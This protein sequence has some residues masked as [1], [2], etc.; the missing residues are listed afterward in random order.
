M[1]QNSVAQH[2]L[3]SFRPQNLFESILKF[4]GYLGSDLYSLKDALQKKEISVDGKHIKKIISMGS[5][6]HFIIFK[7]DD[8]VERGLF[9]KKLP[10]DF[11]PL[12]LRAKYP[13]LSFYKHLMKS[14][15]WF[16]APLAMLSVVV[17]F[18]FLILMMKG[19]SESILLSDLIHKSLICD[20]DC[21][22][23][24]VDFSYIQL[25]VHATNLVYILFP[26][27]FSVLAYFKLKNVYIRRA[28]IMQG[29]LM[30]GV[31]ISI[32]LKND[33]NFADAQEYQKWNELKIEIGLEDHEL[34]IAPFLS[35]NEKR[36]I[37]SEESH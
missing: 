18:T 7:K 24:V 11:N 13:L 27:L 10:L 23:K 8:Q 6:L 17:F 15:H 2:N 32:G 25:L 19:N 28:V 35:K 5:D 16:M 4:Y 9:V 37:A 21:V 36:E 20:Q 31:G 29:I 3:I 14:F 34:L 30:L 12:V 22:R 26:I 33:Q 1:D